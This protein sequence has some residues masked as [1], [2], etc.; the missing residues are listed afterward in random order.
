MPIVYTGEQDWS[1]AL[2]ANFPTW[3]GT[4]DVPVESAEEAAAPETP[5]LLD[6]SRFQALLAELRPYECNP[7]GLANMLWSCAAV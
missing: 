2:S 7:Q 1:W 4:L 6:D 5:S 3:C